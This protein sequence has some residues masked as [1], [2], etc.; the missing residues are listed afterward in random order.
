MAR[1]S[2]LSSE[3]LTGAQLTEPGWVSMTQK[4]LLLEAAS[5]VVGEAVLG[6]IE[7]SLPT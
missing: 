6:G 5:Q 7:V 1:T 2:P 4:F 3:L